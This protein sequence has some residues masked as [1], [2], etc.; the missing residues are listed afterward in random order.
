[1]GTDADPIF[2]G[3]GEGLA[4][5]SNPV[6]GP[7]IFKVRGEQTGAR[8]QRSKAL[9]LREKARRYTG[10]RT[11]MRSGTP[12]RAPFV[13]GSESRY[14]LPQPGRFSSSRS[15]RFIRGRT[16]A[17][18]RRDC[19]S[20]SLPPVLSD[21]SS[22]SPTWTPMCPRRRVQDARGRG[23]DDRRRAA[24]ERIASHVRAASARVTFP[25]AGPGEG[26]PRRV[27][28]PPGGVVAVSTAQ[29]GRPQ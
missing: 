18:S 22:G 13:C 12:S 2:L 17:V 7:L 25:H 27:G 21:S 15:R 10:T 16:W 5:G 29:R 14:E 23:W 4:I 9:P 11:K 26:R 28:A 20:S 19:S 3:P 6:G 1:M 8:W 24:F